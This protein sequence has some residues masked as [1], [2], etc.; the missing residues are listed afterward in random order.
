MMNDRRLLIKGA[1]DFSIPESHLMD[2]H[3][4]VNE[5]NTEVAMMS[6]TIA[7]LKLENSEASS[8]MNKMKLSICGQPSEEKCAKLRS[9][10]EEMKQEKNEEVR[11][12]K[13][14]L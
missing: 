13:D 10:M 8:K 1:T 6:E 9:E 14:D 3:A 7:A 5:R 11:K 2:M 12:L 4:L